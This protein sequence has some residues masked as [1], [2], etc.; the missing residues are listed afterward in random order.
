MD[1]KKLKVAELRKELSDR[2]LDPAG[3]KPILVKRL[4]DALTKQSNVNIGSTAT[5]NANTIMPTLPSLDSAKVATKPSTVA[6]IIFNNNLTNSN[7]STSVG[8]NA[9]GNVASREADKD[10]ATKKIRLSTAMP[11][12]AA[13]TPG[14]TTSGLISLASQTSM[15]STP[16]TSPA[17]SL[18]SA[19]VTTNNILIQPKKEAEGKDRKDGKE[20]LDDAK[21]IVDLSILNKDAVDAVIE[22]RK[23]RAE[24]FG[25]QVV[26]NED[27]KHRERS[28]RFGG[29]TETIKKQKFTKSPGTSPVAAKVVVDPETARK[30][31]Q[32]FG[33]VTDQQ[34]AEKRKNRANRFAPAV[35]SSAVSTPTVPNIP[36]KAKTNSSSITAPA[37]IIILEKKNS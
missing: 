22:T 33:T 27:E 17:I 2:G 29:D 32:K 13:S 37:P 4:E 9:A 21:K 20:T 12:I 7:A 28:R 10:K 26:L 11:T 24:R 14:T 31:A 36:T 6:K 30:R 25:M 5:P 34:E 18:V 8:T 16:L 35:N 19:S 15:T 3:I 23:R 1:P